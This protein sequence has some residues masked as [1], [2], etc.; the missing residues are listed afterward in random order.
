MERVRGIEP[1]LSAWELATDPDR[2]AVELD[3]TRSALRGIARDAPW[4]P[5]ADPGFG[6]AK[7][8]WRQERPTPGDREVVDRMLESVVSSDL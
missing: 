5:L 1:P 4:L 3:D 2:P 8:T 7:G 6:H